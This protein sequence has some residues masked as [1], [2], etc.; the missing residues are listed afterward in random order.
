MDEERRF[1]ASDRRSVA[2]ATPS[3][4]PFVAGTGVVEHDAHRG[5]LALPQTSE[6]TYSDAQLQ[7]YGGLA[8]KNYPWRPPLHLTL[9][10]RFAP[11]VRGTA[12]WGFWNNPLSRGVPA[13]PRAVWFFWASPP[14]AMELAQDVPG[15][16]WK[17]AT[18]D[19]GRPGALVWAPFAP[20]VLLLCRH[21]GVRRR[22]W[23]RVQRALAVEERVLDLDRTVWH[24]YDVYWLEK[25][26]VWGVDGHVVHTA[27]VSPRGP[28]GLVLWVDNQWVRVTPAGSFG[29]GLLASTAPQWVEYRDL[30]ITTPT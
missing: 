21:D 15:H 20:L 28:L 22:L 4:A 30:R 6:D 29:A 26:V 1:A 19:A 11:D 3:L 9:E 27:A 23:P 17:A 14:S 16:G 5:T 7:D 24:R 12:G 25:R 18:I 10:A 2:F 8:R 13:L